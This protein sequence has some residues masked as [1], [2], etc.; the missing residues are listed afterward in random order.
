MSWAALASSGY[1]LHLER[2]G[3][4]PPWRNVSS[5]INIAGP[6]SGTLEERIVQGRRRRGLAVPI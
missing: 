5:R 2:D 6:P 4:P 1:A 3:P